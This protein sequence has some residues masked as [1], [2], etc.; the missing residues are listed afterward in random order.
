V[1]VWDY[2]H[3]YGGSGSEYCAALTEAGDGGFCP[4][5][6]YRIVCA[7]MSD[8]YLVNVDSNVSMSGQG[9]MAELVMTGPIRSSAPRPVI[10]LSVVTPIPRLEILRIFFLLLH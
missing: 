1:E 10:I 7:G 2:P 5:W 4:V 9:R 6:L 8:I 3:Y